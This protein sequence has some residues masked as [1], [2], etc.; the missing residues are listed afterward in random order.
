MKIGLLGN[1][2]IQGVARSIRLFAPDVE[3]LL[4]SVSFTAAEQA[5]TIEMIA[6]DLAD[7][8]LALIQSLDDAQPRLT[9]LFETVIARATTRRWPPILF[10]GFHPDC[11]Y[12]RHDGRV[13]DGIAGPYHSAL[14]CAAWA[15]GLP[16]LR[17]ARLFNAFTYTA[18][19]Y[20][21]A[22]E[23]AAVLLTAQADRHGFQ[24]STFLDAPTAPF[25]HTINHP[26][27]EVLQ[28]IAAQA[29][30]MSGI[31]RA[32][33]PPLADDELSKG[34]IWPTYPELARRRGWMP[35][36]ASWDPSDMEAVARQ[37]YEALEPLGDFFTGQPDT[38]GEHAILKARTF[39]RDYVK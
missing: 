4:R 15:E 10:R 21:D 33:T 12:V 23:E 11:I 22:F 32:P 29:L 14:L 1:C 9:N 5:E 28:S 27:I 38:P 37:A 16:P 18:L 31:T 24:F 6:N 34:P 13:V 39:I 19:G 17:A 8:D 20:F 36:P 2:Q 35:V 26:R 30:D 3:I 25:M 7:C